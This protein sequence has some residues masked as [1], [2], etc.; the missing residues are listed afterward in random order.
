MELTKM[1]FSFAGNL[2]WP[3]TILIIVS[4]FRR[5]LI[6]LIPN[7][8][9][10]EAGGIKLNIEKRVEEI[11]RATVE[12]A[13]ETDKELIFQKEERTAIPIQQQSSVD[14]ASTML[15]FAA[16]KSFNENLKYNIY[17][18]PAY[19]NHNLP[20]QYIGLYKNGAIQ[21]VGKVSKIVY[22]D[23]KG[24]KL[25]ETYDDDLIRLT[26]DEYNRIKN[27]IEETGYY[28]LKEDCKFFLVEKFYE[29]YHRLDYAIRGKQY[30]WLND[31]KDFQLG[32][33]AQKLAALLQETPLNANK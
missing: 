21:A 32:M 6:Q 18:D 31:I 10:V 22:C 12:V 13:N 24:G 30:F 26:Q 25:E 19:R 11:V 28:D 3:A 7:I 29:T 2:L 23:Y 27:I 15:A 17:Y 9:S 16:G 1:I 5:Y 20:F 4:L 8:R 14:G 33:S